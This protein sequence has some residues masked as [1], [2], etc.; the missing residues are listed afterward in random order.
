MQICSL[1]FML[2][3]RGF[4][5][6]VAGQSLSVEKLQGVALSHCLIPNIHLFQ[7]GPYVNI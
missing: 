1:F 2:W 5:V 6:G 7:G 3:G 4:D